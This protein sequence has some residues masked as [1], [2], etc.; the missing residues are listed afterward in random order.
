MFLS[1][2][3]ISDR[4]INILKAELN[5]LP[6]LNQ[7][8]ADAR[9]TG[10][11][12]R[13]SKL[14][15]E[16]FP[17]CMMFA[18]EE[19]GQ[20]SLQDSCNDI[21]LH[22]GVRVSKVA[23]HK[24]FNDNSIDFVREVLARQMLAKME[25]SSQGDWSGFSA[26]IISDSCK[27]Q[28]PKALSEAYPPIGRFAAGNSLMNMQYALDLKSGSWRTLEF[29]QARENDQG[30]SGMHLNKIGKAELHIRD[31][32]YITHT[33]LLGVIRREAY[34][35]NRLHTSCRPVE[36]P[37]G[38][39]INWRQKHLQMIAG[40]QNISETLITIGKGDETIECRLVAVPVPRQV[41]EQR[42]RKANIQAKRQGY[43]LTEEYKSRARL[44]LFIT[45]AESD[46]LQTEMVA[47]LYRL[48]WQIE[49]MFKSWESLF[50]IHKV[51][52]IK[53]ARLE[54]QLFA[55]LPRI[56]INWKICRFIDSIDE[57]R[58]KDRSFSMWK[59]FKYLRT[60]AESIRKMVTKEISVLKWYNRYIIAIIKSLLLEPKKGKKAAFQILNEIFRA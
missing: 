56:K 32:G 45:N 60:I 29:R 13:A 15:P 35:L 33:Y 26:V 12:K 24:R 22:N 14:A 9:E 46:K 7:V 4:S 49:L 28:L 17:E 40:K 23:L 2:D 48:R 31:L 10:F 18:E 42:I 43:T 19:H 51:R 20:L 25:F 11:M 47:E 38:K 39:S 1:S 27:F 37:T 50:G 54:C 3:R 8:H 52:A 53:K 55:R 5:L 44:S 36:V 34:F 57:Q 21:L 58:F 30:Y 59:V 41:W 16:H 6:D